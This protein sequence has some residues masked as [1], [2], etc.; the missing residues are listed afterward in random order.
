MLIAIHDNKTGFTPRWVAYCERE[1]IPY[2][3]VN[4]YDTDIVRQVADCDAFMW[5]YHQTDYR[6]ML[7]ARQ[8]LRALEAA[9]KTVFPNER[10]NWHFDDKVGQKYLFEAL[11]L[12]LV[13]SYAF[14]ER[15][16]ALAWTKKTD[17]PK[18]FKLRGGAGA[19]NV[20]A[21]QHAGSATRFIRRAFSRGFPQFDRWNYLRD[22][23][24]KGRSL[25]QKLRGLAAGLY[26]LVVSTEYA[27]MH[28]AE[29]GYA[30]FQD[31]VPGQDSDTRVCVVGRRAFA[32]KRMVRRGDF[33]ASG[34]GRIVYD[35][36][37]IDPRC[38]RIAFETNEKLRMQSAAF[39]FVFLPD[40]S[41]RIVEVSYGFVPEGYDLCEGYWTDDLRFHPGT[42][43][44]FCG[45]MVEEVTKQVQTE[46]HNRQ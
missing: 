32:I 6:D 31:F 36:G 17:F 41:P 40:G 33:R 30:Y 12:P 46:K 44:D 10:T 7:F 39:D 15:A 29:R 25:R 27:R 19:S 11:G 35:T 1:G 14:Y 24:K 8:L 20:K 21:A 2:R 43:F 42:H 23:F 16:T 38:I 3:L 28:G 9:G 5:H 37:Q 13:R 18:V 22:R 34:S 26:R 45:W 4:A